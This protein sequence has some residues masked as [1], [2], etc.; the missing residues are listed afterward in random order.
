MSRKCLKAVKALHALK[1][2][3]ALYARY[4][5]I[6]VEKRTLIEKSKI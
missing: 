1:A 4:T 6:L 3:K 5:N 2:M